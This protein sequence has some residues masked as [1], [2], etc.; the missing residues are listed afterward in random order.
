[1]PP[2]VVQSPGIP[3][4]TVCQDIRP[5][6]DQPDCFAVRF[7]EGLDTRVRMI[8]AFYA[9]DYVDAFEG[10]R[11]LPVGRAIMARIFG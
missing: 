5:V 4:K 11:A 7:D 3:L 1:M 6:F 8:R 9:G 10:V 2:A